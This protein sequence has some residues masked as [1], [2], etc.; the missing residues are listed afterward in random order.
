MGKKKL[1]KVILRAETNTR[2]AGPALADEASDTSPAAIS[3]SATSPSH[4]QRRAFAVRLVERFAL[5]SGVGALIPIPFIDA[6][7]VGALQIQMLRRISQ[8]YRIPFSDN[9]G[10]SII[11]SIAGAMIPATSGIGA[12]SLLKSIPVAGTIVSGLAMPTLSAG[13]TYAIGMAFIE[14]IVSG[15]TLLDFD[16]RNSREGKD[17]TQAET[18]AAK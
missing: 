1:P 16:L 5:W 10:K 15:G 11:A 9:A 2:E 17:S 8:I 4:I 12:A 18:A 7:A 3:F 14:H 6:A 13:A